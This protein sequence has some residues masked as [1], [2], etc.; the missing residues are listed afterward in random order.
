[1]IA[2]IKP[3]IA[4]VPPPA[5]FPLPLPPPFRPLFS[6]LGTVRARARTFCLEQMTAEKLLTRKTALALRV[7]NPERATNA[8]TGIWQV[9][10]GMVV[11]WYGM[12]RYGMVWHG[13]IWDGMVVWYGV[14]WLLLL[15]LLLF[16]H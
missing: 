12:V 15:L 14:V 4:S 16:S 1:M 2:R 11:V 10:Y 6:A 9:W 7:I 8:I 13:M 3:Y 5:P